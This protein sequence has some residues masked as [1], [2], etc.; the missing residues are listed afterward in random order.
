M[1]Q[2][3][4]ADV[5][6]LILMDTTDDGI[7]VSSQWAAHTGKNR[8][9]QKLGVP[10]RLRRF[11][12]PQL[13]EFLTRVDKENL[14]RT[15]DSVHVRGQR[16]AAGGQRSTRLACRIDAAPGV[17]REKQLVHVLIGSHIKD[18]LSAL[19]KA[20][21]GAGELAIRVSSAQCE[22]GDHVSTCTC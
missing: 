11:P 9:R 17:R 8:R 20:A 1:N 5:I 12:G 3:V 13:L 4:A 14:F 2:T 6:Q 10:R 16:T 22:P 18:P 15:C 19:A 21:A 7:N